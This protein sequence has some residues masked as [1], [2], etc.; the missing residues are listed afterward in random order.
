MCETTNVCFIKDLPKAMTRIVKIECRCFGIFAG[1]YQMFSAI[2]APYCLAV[3]FNEHLGIRIE[4]LSFAS[5]FSDVVE[6]RLGVNHVSD[7]LVQ[8]RVQMTLEIL[9]DFVVEF[10]GPSCSRTGV[11]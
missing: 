1:L 6:G 3:F 8:F 7:Y 5:L 10:R 2:A 4:E 9:Q 11:F